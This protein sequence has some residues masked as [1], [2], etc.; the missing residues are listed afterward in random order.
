MKITFAENLKKLRRARDLTQDDLARFLGV[1]FQAVSKWERNEGYP[2]I[3]M[4]P[5]IANY[6]EVTVDALLGNDIISKEERIEQYRKE[7]WKLNKHSTMDEAVDI[8][9][10]AYTE[11]PFEWGIIEIY[12]LSLTRGFSRFPDEETLIELRRL[13][14]FVMEKCPDSV[15]RNRAICIMIYAEDDD[16]V[17][18]W[19]QE[20]PDN[21]NF[22]ES[23][24]REDR[25]A[26]REQWEL[27]SPLKQQNTYDILNEL[28]YKMGIYYEPSTPEW[29]IESRERRLKLWNLLF[30]GTD[31]ILVSH[32]FINCL[33]ELADAYNRAGRT[34]DA[35]A[36]LTEAVDHYEEHKKYGESLKAAPDEKVRM[37]DPMWD[38]LS[39][40]AYP[41]TKMSYL[42][43]K[44]E[45]F[46][47]P[48]PEYAK[49][50][51]LR[52]LIER[53]KKLTEN[54]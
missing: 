45:N 29:Q 34:D 23:E 33:V 18:R 42:L 32:R 39:F 46:A 30:K 19:L 54:K 26:N 4:L 44:L 20:T 41:K 35:I 15:V 6:F 38:K 43:Q 16:H 1:T 28:S 9:K 50:E 22:L 48:S 52:K 11:Y 51:P 2:D 40:Y 53:L 49:N 31:R 14:D 17:E 7:Y 13:C 8:A 37:N 21:F 10:K 47:A 12:I 36:A 24:R 27:F 25:Y 5:V 3:T